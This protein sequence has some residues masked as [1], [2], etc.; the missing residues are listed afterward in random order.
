MP[1]LSRFH[2]IL[3]AMF[4]DDHNPPHF[5]ARYSGDW[6]AFSVHPVQCIEGRLPRRI[7]RLVVRWARL[8][9][10][11]LLENWAL[12]HQQLELSAIDPLD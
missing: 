11:E 12:A 4:H 7:E 2:G 9:E 10:A 8:H 1:R 6:A 3:I 5:H